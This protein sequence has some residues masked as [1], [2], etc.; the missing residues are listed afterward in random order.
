MRTNAWTISK[1]KILFFD[2]LEY[3]L[4]S[5]LKTKKLLHLCPKMRHREKYLTGFY[6]QTLKEKHFIFWPKRAA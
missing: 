3:T 5:S 6:F 4:A 2:S 1:I